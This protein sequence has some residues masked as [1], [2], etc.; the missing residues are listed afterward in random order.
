MLCNDGKPP[1]LYRKID[2]HS[3]HNDRQVNSHVKT[4]LASWMA[5]IDFQLVVDLGK[6]VNYLIKYVTKPEKD[7]NDG[8]YHTIKKSTHD[9]LNA[10]E[11]VKTVLQ[12]KW[13]SY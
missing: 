13:G 11:S 5:N 1:E 2:F 10:G 7:M 6:V 9:N 3:K 4:F 12:N 8:I